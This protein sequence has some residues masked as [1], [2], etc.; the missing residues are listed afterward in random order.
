MK[1][2]LICITTCNRVSAIKAVIWDYINFCKKND[3]FDFLISLDGDDKETV[4]YCEKHN[5]PLVYSKVREGV[6][7]SKNRVL[8]TYSEFDYYFFI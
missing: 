4:R 5:I 7:L 1:K 3:S 2:S 8:K 6:G